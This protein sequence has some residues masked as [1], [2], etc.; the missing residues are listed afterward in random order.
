[1]TTITKQE[2]EQIIENDIVLVSELSEAPAV[3]DKIG[4]SPIRIKRILKEVTN[5]V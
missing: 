5:L 1:L 2:K 3:L 4:I